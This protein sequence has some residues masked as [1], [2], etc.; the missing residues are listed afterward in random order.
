M[1][2]TSN[3]FK[4]NIEIDKIRGRL[5]EIWEGLEYLQDFGHVG[6]FEMSKEELK[7]RSK[8]IIQHLAN[9][10]LSLEH[11]TDACKESYEH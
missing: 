1:E 9:A 10:E 11:V 5:N 3:N 4:T 8:Q 7:L 2:N 6:C